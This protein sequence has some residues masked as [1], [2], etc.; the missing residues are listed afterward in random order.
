[1]VCNHV[2]VIIQAVFVAVIVIIAIV[3]AIAIVDTV[4]LATFFPR[5]PASLLPICLLS[6]TRPSLATVVIVAP[7]FPPVYGYLSVSEVSLL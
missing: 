4:I 6:Y 7:G 5:Y 3:D 2:F 1:M